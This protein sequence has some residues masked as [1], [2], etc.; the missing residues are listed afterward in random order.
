MKCARLVLTKGFPDWKGGSKEYEEIQKKVKFFPSVKS[1]THRERSRWSEFV[2]F[3]EMY[4]QAQSRYY[5]NTTLEDFAA[6]IDLFQ[7]THAHETMESNELFTKDAQC[8]VY[9]LVRTCE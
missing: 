8:S 4:A 1:V 6:Q 9:M 3:K 2:G 5:G 7:Q